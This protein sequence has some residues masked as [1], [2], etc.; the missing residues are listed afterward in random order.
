[1]MLTLAFGLGLLLMW[2]GA[3]VYG[4]SNNEDVDNIGRFIQS[5]GMLALTGGLLLG[6]FVRNDI[7]KHVRLGMLIAGV[8]LLIY[9][10]FW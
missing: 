7:E 4:L 9:I 3:L 1:M 2:I 5:V 8:L 6:G 10:G